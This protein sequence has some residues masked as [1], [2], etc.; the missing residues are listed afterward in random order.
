M[1]SLLFPPPAS[2]VSVVVQRK[3]GFLFFPMRYKRLYIHNVKP[4]LNSNRFGSSYRNAGIISVGAYPPVR[5]S[6]DV[7]YVI[8][9]SCDS[10]R[11]D[12]GVLDEDLEH[13]SIYIIN[14]LFAFGAYMLST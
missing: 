11:M 3:V 13:T 5:I 14:L 4:K 9:L 7:L 8:L 10:R 12:P 1:R 2:N 6:K